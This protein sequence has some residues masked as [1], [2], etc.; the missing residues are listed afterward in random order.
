M[1][2]DAGETDPAFLAS[3]GPD[4]KTAFPHLLREVELWL[5]IDAE[6][7]FRAE[8]LAGQ[9]IEI[10][11]S[12]ALTRELSALNE[13]SWG[14]SAEMLAEWSRNGPPADNA[15]EAAARFG[16]AVIRELAQKAVQH[17]LPMLLDY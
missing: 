13:R 17:R 5:P 8:N 9:Q 16:F 7:T 12:I 11:S 14:A 6:F 10:A 15:F 1:L 2:P 4:Q 3:T